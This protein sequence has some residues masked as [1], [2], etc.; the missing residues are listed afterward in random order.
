MSR[1]VKTGLDYWPR[2]IGLLRDRK[3]RKARMQ[4]GASACLVYEGLLD[5]IYSDKGYYLE[6]GD[7]T[8]DDVVWDILELLQ[9][10]YQ[11]TPQTIEEIIE[12]LVE[13][14]L[15]SGYHFNTKILTSKRV[16]Q[17]YYKCTADRKTIDI[18][19]DIWMLSEA[20]MQEMSK[21]SP[22]LTNFIYRPINGVNRTINEVN[23]P[24]NPQSKV[25][26]SKGK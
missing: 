3:F 18:N 8:K 13:C 14:E 15:F 2:D 19:F 24:N 23:Q 20:E 4:Y 26:E 6:Y 5:L 10:K 12:A 1:P 16:Q 22:I 7:K 9:G 11:P 25:K 21:K 17:T